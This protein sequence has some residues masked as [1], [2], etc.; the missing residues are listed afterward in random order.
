MGE[1]P[2]SRILAAG[3]GWGNLSF[4]DDS[5]GAF[6]LWPFTL[7]KGVQGRSF[8]ERKDDSAAPDG[9]ETPRNPFKS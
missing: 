1:S 2:L 3:C 5:R 6:A 8:A 7:R 9:I 4:G